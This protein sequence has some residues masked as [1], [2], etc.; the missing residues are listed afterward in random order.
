[1]RFLF[2]LL[3]LPLACRDQYPIEPGPC[4]ASRIEGRW[5]GESAPFWMYDFNPPHLRQQVIVAG[6][7]VADQSYIYGTSAD[8]L[9]ASGPGG[10][11]MWLVCFPNDST[12]EYREWDVWKW[13][14]VF[15][16]NRIE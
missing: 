13:S 16:L 4:D 5:Q 8:T 14:P 3:L 9:W 15:Y 12:C 6:V 7:V 11:R 10:E 2:F 1:M